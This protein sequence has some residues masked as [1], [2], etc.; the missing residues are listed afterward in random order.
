MGRNNTATGDGTAGPE[1]YCRLPGPGRERRADTDDP[2]EQTDARRQCRCAF[3]SQIETNYCGPH[4]IVLL[5][6]TLANGGR[7]SDC[8]GSNT[9]PECAGM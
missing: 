2:G 3:H 6:P 1:V 8:S 5:A 7:S 9:G 4:T